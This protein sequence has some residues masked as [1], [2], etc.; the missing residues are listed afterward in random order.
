MKALPLLFIF[1]ISGLQ[2]QEDTCIDF[3]DF[4]PGFGF[5]NGTSLTEDGILMTIG[6][7]ISPA[8]GQTFNGT[9]VIGSSSP[10]LGNALS[11]SNAT[12][13]LS[14]DC[15]QK[16]QLHY[17]NNGGNMNISINGQTEIIG[18]VNPSYSIGGVDV[19]VNHNGNGGTM[20]FETSSQNIN[21]L[22]IGGQEFVVDHICFLP[23][24]DPSCYDFEDLGNGTLSPGDIYQEDGNKVSIIPYDNNSGTASRSTNNLAG[25]L[26]N[27][28]VFDNAGAQFQIGC[29][30]EVGFNY[31]QGDFG[32][33]LTINGQS[34][35][36]QD[37]TQLNGQ[38]IDGV[39]IQV[40][41]GQVTLT[42]IIETLAI[43]GNELAI[44]HLCIGECPVN[45]IDYEGENP[46]TKYTI[47]EQFAEDGITM[48]VDQFTG[49]GDEQVL[50]SDQQ[51]AGH[52]GNDAILIDTMLA[53]DIPCAT[54]ISLQFGQYDSGVFIRHNNGQS[55]KDSILDF[56]GQSIGG[57]LVEV[58]AINLNGSLIGTLTLTGQ[59]ENFTIGGTY[60]AIDHVCHTPCPDPDCF[61]F[62]VFP[63]G[64]VYDEGDSITEDLTPLA[65]SRFYNTGS[66]TLEITDENLAN[67][68][69]NEARLR[70]AVATF[71]F[72]CASQVTIQYRQNTFDTRLGVNGFFGN[73][74]SF[75]NFAGTLNGFNVS[76]TSSTITI[77]GNG[78][79]NIIIGG[80]DVSIDHICHIDCIDAPNCFDFEDLPTNGSYSFDGPE[81]FFFSENNLFLADPYEID[82]STFIDDGTI[83]V[84]TS[85]NAGHQGQELRFQNAGIFVA[86]PNGCIQNPTFRFGEYSGSINIEINNSGLLIFDNLSD[87]NG[88]TI[89]GVSVSVNTIP[90]GAGVL[91]YASLQ[92]LVTNLKIGGQNLYLDHLCYEDC[93]PISV[94]NACLISVAPIN[95]TERQIVID[96]ESQGPAVLRIQESTDLGR[97]DTWRSL[98]TS[99][100]THSSNPTLQRCTATLPL[101]T[102][103]H[104]FRVR[105]SYN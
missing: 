83:T 3:E 21:S 84:S 29:S 34:L 75:T 1:L 85:N 66:G 2:A 55:F 19:T 15:V 53:F 60:L 104:F 42:G 76:V 99:V 73:A 61:D 74:G 49:T 72:L 13:E 47:G 86:V 18:I 105:A 22:C 17:G 44:D 46:G 25:G 90:N 78:I 70:N 28:I 95:Q 96:V 11:L 37:M 69:G 50:I 81:L 100:T 57:V 5:S 67:H 36:A 88:L 31:A 41:N 92:G 10:H 9:A 56:D 87:L 79:Q 30:G 101:G 23:C 68:V 26:G 35:Q 24:D 58:D 94:S 8:N 64:I 4:S 59:I 38:T 82:S 80:A 91:G 97:S 45:C 62:E 52:F 32:I 20:C 33:T 7:Y 43:A 40:A 14:F 89:G 16:V 103:K 93:P 39:T 63:F 27:E 71:D 51:L 102:S 48:T 98:S 12:L 65:I 6:P 77:S 54:E